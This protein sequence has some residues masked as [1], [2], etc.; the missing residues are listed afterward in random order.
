MPSYTKSQ[1]IEEEIVTCFINIFEKTLRIAIN[2]SA[3]CV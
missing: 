1:M 2:T 3:T